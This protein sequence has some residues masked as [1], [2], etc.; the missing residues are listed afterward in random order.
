MAD[1]NTDYDALIKQA[2]TKTFYPTTGRNAVA[3]NKDDAIKAMQKRADHILENKGAL[4]PG[5]PKIAHANQDKPNPTQLY[6]IAA[7]KNKGTEVKIN[8]IEAEGVIRL[9]IANESAAAGGKEVDPKKLAERLKEITTRI[10]D[11]TEPKKQIDIELARG[12]AE[13]QARANED[14]NP[15]GNM[16]IG[17]DYKKRNGIDR[18]T[19][20]ANKIMEETRAAVL[21]MPKDVRKA[22]GKEHG[23]ELGITIIKGKEPKELKELKEAI[24]AEGLSATSAVTEEQI[25]KLQPKID[26]LKES[27]KPSA[28]PKEKPK[29]ITDD[30]GAL[31]SPKDFDTF[32]VSND[33]PGASVPPMNPEKAAQN[34]KPN[35]TREV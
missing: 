9:A 17:D 18:K 6:A 23:F 24:K 1:K 11:A 19:D 27:L 7:F 33:K 12:L 15:K 31:V 14:Q 34:A 13:Y 22:I 32:L 25:K 26:S 29:G 3:E 4:K 2:E 35:T 16:D 20:A 8:G 5:G 28:K 21:E 10:V 30:F